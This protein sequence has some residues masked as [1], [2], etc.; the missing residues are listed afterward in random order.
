MCLACKL[1]EVRNYSEIPCL[2]VYE[3]KTVEM[4]RITTEEWAKVNYSKEIFLGNKCR[5]AYVTVQVYSLIFIWKG[6]SQ[7]VFRGRKKKLRT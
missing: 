3:K 4:Y 2:C 6:R 5:L 7:S 1:T